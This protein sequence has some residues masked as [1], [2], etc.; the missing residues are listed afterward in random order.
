M[1][2]SFGSAVRTILESRNG[3]RSSEVFA[4]I[5]KLDS[6][7]K[8]TTLALLFGKDAASTA[9]YR[10]LSPEDVV[11]HLMAMTESMAKQNQVA[12]SNSF[13]EGIVGLLNA[14]G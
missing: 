5:Q 1:S 2:T 4:E 7:D 10:D 3:H 8:D 12:T 11:K 14:I 13:V 6:A 9:E